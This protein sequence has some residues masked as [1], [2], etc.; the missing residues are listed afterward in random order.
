MLNWW[1]LKKEIWS[2]IVKM[3]RLSGD[4]EWL[5]AGI[6]VVSENGIHKAL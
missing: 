2:K 6:N 1:V 4:I 5:N 3:V